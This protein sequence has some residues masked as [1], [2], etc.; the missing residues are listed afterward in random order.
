V[1]TDTANYTR[2]IGECTNLSVGYFR[3]HGPTEHT[4]LAF[5][6]RLRNAL[7]AGDWTKLDFERKP[8]EKDPDLMS[9]FDRYDRYGAH[10]YGDD[11]SPAEEDLVRFCEEYP[12]HVA[13][14]LAAY[15]Y[16]VEDLD[17]FDPEDGR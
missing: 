14:F 9:Y 11:L 7:V 6:Y 12:W 8:G 16:G 1:F 3:Q 17:L 4:S 10:A 15:G 2:L 5:A 13:K